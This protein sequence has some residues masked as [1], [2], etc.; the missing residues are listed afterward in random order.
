[1]AATNEHYKIGLLAVS[2]SL[3]FVLFSFGIV[4]I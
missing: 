1:M 2:I 3:E 4:S